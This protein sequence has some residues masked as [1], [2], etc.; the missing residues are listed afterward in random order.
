MLV[1][2]RAWAV[3][4]TALL[5]GVVAGLAPAAPAFAATWSVVNTPND[6]AGDNLLIGA[7]ALSTTDVWAVG[8]ADYAEAP[9]RR[10]I[11][12]RWNGAGWALAPTAKFGGQL[13]GVDG[14]KTTDVWA[15]GARDV[16]LGGGTTTSGPLAQHWN[17]TAWSIVPSPTPAGATTAH[18]TGVKSFGSSAWA[19][20]QYS[21]VD[22]GVLR[23]RTLVQRW[24]G[25]GW[26]IV[27]SPDPDPNQNLLTD[28]DGTS[29]T[30]VWAIGNRGDD[31]N[32]STLAGLVVHWDGAAWK[33]VDVPGSA[34]DAQFSTPRLQDVVALAKD[35]V[36]IVGSAFHRGLFRTV[37]YSLHFDGRTWQR[38]FLTTATD[39][40]VGFNGVAALSTDRVYAV[41][42]VTARWNGTAW[43]QEARVPGQLSDATAAGPSTVWGVGFR[44]GTSLRTLAMRGLNA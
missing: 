28:V 14:S 22:L 39:T 21:T 13:S 23:T 35:D 41:G 6:S 12:A 24:N 40:G 8:R 15:V 18:L 9:T 20:G 43:V 19:V 25:S 38:A 34:S 36:W 33:H 5:A 29:D 37:P 4:A 44:F 1:K 10:P 31:G 27:P 3:S 2:R 32:G 17:G 16:D 26:S 30:D 42:E 11:V 7:D